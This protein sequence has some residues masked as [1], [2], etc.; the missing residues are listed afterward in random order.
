MTHR[1]GRISDPFPLW[2]Q[3]QTRG[4]SSD[5]GIASLFSPAHVA[6]AATAI[7]EVTPQ[8]RQVTDI[9]NRITLDDVVLQASGSSTIAATS[10]KSGEAVV[11]LGGGNRA[12]NYASSSKVVTLLKALAIFGVVIG[13]LRLKNH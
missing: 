8:W 11:R 6:S 12:K 2:L 4:W 7:N 3:K 1:V 10:R 5:S 9:N 13:V